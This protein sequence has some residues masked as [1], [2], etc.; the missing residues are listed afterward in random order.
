M[1]GPVSPERDWEG[2]CQQEDEGHEDMRS[3]DD[4]E[5][6]DPRVLNDVEGP[7]RDELEAHMAT[8]VPFRS[9]CPY[10]IM[11]KAPAG[12]QNLPAAPGGGTATG[13]SCWGRLPT[14]LLGAL[15]TF[16]VAQQAQGI[17]TTHLEQAVPQLQLSTRQ[18]LARLQ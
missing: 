3:S 2:A 4:E 9:W 5:G 15:R 18:S 11:G 14:A 13:E 16:C 10:C 7:P 1:I 6:Q 12:G 8:H 17:D